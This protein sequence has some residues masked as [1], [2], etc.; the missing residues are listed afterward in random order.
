MPLRILQHLVESSGEIVSRRA[1]QNLLWNGTQFGDFEQGLNSAM[2]VLRMALG[3]SGRKALYIGTVAGAGYRF[4]APIR[5]Q[6]SGE[7]SAHSLP[8]ALPYGLTP[9]TN[10]EA[11]DQFLLAMNFLG[12]QN[13]IPQ[14]RK[15][16][17]RA[18]ELDPHFGA[19]RLQ[20]AGLII[21]EILNG[22]ANDEGL[23]FQ[24]EQDLHEA[25][26][27]LPANDGLLLS[28]EAAVYLAQ[29]RLDRVPKGKMEQ[30]WREQGSNGQGSPVWLV[31]LLMLEGQ[32]EVPLAI[33]RAHLER[34]SLENPTRMFIGELLRTQGD[35]DGAIRILE[36]AV[37][38]GPRHPTAAWFL[39]M[40]CL[41]KGQPEKA[42]TLLEGMRPE[43]EKNYQWRHGLAILLA[44]EGRREE[45]LQAM[46]EDTLKFARLTWSV[47]SAT[48]DFYALVGDRSKAIE[49]LQLAVARGDER[50]S[51]FRR[52]ERLAA[53]RDDPRFQLLL[54]SVEA[55]HQ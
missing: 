34:N 3:D 2:N 11:N 50:I 12:V 26:R 46:D 47:M 15:T 19:A 41:D 5:R 14:A 45:A 28:T 30:W 18:L 42:H 32:T 52:N 51:Y 17:E 49:W 31:V 44:T 36:R 43:F 9:S 33:L 16:I 23:L 24:A 13:D 8:P 10:Q 25:K 6:G 40:A 20:R 54:K 29:G 55:R 22:Y 37:Q 7:Q 27:T 1:L 53:L 35:T 48:A 21:I 38:Q 39:T 4:T